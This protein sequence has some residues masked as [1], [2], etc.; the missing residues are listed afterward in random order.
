VMTA[1]LLGG[2]PQHAAGVASGA[3]N[4][5]RQAGGAIGVALFGGLSDPH[6]FLF[7]S[8][9]LLAASVTAVSLT[10]T[11]KPA[12]QPAGTMAGPRPICR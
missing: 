11:A 12:Q 7:G 3:L 8:A 10:R 4:A 1:S 6:A 9:L 5:V 2:V